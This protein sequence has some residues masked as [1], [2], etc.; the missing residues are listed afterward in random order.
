MTKYDEMVEHLAKATDLAASIDLN[1]GVEALIEA[2]KALETEYRS[3]PTLGPCGCTDYHMADCPLMTGGSD[4]GMTKEDYLSMP[5]E[6]WE[7]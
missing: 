5:D 7:D 2:G 3:E 1:Q 6:Y 4:S